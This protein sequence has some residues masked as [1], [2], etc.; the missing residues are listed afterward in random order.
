MR[1]EN[2]LRSLLPY[3][4]RTLNVAFAVFGSI[5][6]KVCDIYRLEDGKLAEHWDVVQPLPDPEDPGANGNG[7][8]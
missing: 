8:F 6:S 3:L 7:S 1:V 5:P 2:L 4:T